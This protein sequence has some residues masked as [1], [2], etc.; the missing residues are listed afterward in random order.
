MLTGRYPFES[1]DDLMRG[2]LSCNLPAYVPQNICDIVLGFLTTD[3]LTRL[4]CQDALDL[5]EESSISQR[6]ATIDLNDPNFHQIE[7]E[8]KKHPDVY[9][10][11]DKLGDFDYGD[12]PTGLCPNR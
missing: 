11:R 4:T 8:L 1:H 9:K 6:F 5:L 12:E 7:E 3:P 2:E 10:I